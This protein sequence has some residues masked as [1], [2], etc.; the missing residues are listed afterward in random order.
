MS[1]VAMDVRTDRDVRQVLDTLD[2]DVRA[3]EVIAFTEADELGH[4][5]GHVRNNASMSV[6]EIVYEESGQADGGH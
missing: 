4:T 2:R 1:H 3:L 6:L 5:Y